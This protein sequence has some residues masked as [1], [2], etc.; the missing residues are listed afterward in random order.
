MMSL[1]VKLIIAAILLITG[2]FSG[3]QVQSWKDNS[4]KL[5][6]INKQVDTGEKLQEDS[7]AIIKEK[8]V[9]EAKVKIV[10]R[11]I[12]DEINEQNDDN[13]CFTADSL[14]LWNRAI[15]G[16]D[17]NRSESVTT[18]E[19]IDPAEGNEASV[20]QVLNSAS[21]N[22]ETCNSNSIIHNALIDKVESLKDKMCVC[23]E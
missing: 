7:V 22:F 3:C 19:S 20:K 21:D 4:A 11:N 13:I 16:E 18:A 8:E 5:K 10:Y 2:F 6:S 15:S 23:S 17:T 12:K 9:A 1:Q 14:S